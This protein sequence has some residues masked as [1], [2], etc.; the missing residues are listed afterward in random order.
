[1]VDTRD[2]N[3]N[4]CSSVCLTEMIEYSES[5]VIGLWLIFISVSNCILFRKTI[6]K[7]FGHKI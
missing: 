1:M 7:L 6:V 2:V 5:T 3:I 4:T